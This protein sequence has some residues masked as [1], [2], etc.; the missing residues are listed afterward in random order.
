M[1]TITA[2]EWRRTSGRCIPDLLAGGAVL[3]TSNGKPLY[4]AHP[5]GGFAR[6]AMTLGQWK[7]LA[8]WDTG[9]VLERGSVLVMRGE[10]PLYEARLPE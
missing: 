9:L 10:R 8:G 4:E 2:S 3:I 7:A 6:Q 1:K 5:P